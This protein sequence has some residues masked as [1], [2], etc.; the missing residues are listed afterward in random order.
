MDLFLIDEPLGLG[1]S[2]D[3]PEEMAALEEDVRRRG[4]QEAICVLK[5]AGRYRIY[6]GKSRYLVAKNLGLKTVPVNVLW[7]FGG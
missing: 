5:V 3:R 4:I 6:D 2:S 7:E 1:G